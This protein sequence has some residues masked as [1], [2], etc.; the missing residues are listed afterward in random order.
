MA[1]GMDGS[2]C[3]VVGHWAGASG[4][5]V[6]KNILRAPQL[7]LAWCSGVAGLQPSVPASER[8]SER[9]YERTDGRANS[10]DL[11]ANR[12]AAARAGG[13]RSR[14]ADR[15]DRCALRGAGRREWSSSQWVGD[16]SAGGPPSSC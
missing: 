14:R 7:V 15:Q 2:W 5:G 11:P 1:D 4:V 6:A 12:I 10:R 3:G 8:A 16:E 13:Q 9:K